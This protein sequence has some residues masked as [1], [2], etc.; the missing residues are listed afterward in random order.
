M[1][2]SGREPLETIFMKRTLRNVF[3]VLTVF[4]ISRACVVIGIF[5][6]RKFL[7]FPADLSNKVLEKTWWESLARW[8]AGYYIDIVLNGYHYLPDGKTHNIAFFPLY[9]LLIRIVDD[10]TKLSPLM[11][12]IIISNACF[13]VALLLLHRY[14]EKYHPDSNPDLTAMLMAFFPFG[15]FFSSV[16]TE[17]LFLC[18]C[19]FSFFMFREGKTMLSAIGL[20]LMTAT[21]LAG[22]FVVPALGLSYLFT[23]VIPFPKKKS[24]LKGRELLNLVVWG[25]VAISGFVCFAAY[26]QISFGHWDAFIR[27]QIAWKDRVG[28]FSSL[29]SEMHPDLYNVMNIVPAGILLGASILFLF[30]KNYRIYSV[31]G[32]LAVL[33]PLSTGTF[34]SMGRYSMVF[35]PLAIYGGCLLKKTAILRDIALMTSSSLLVVLSTLFAKYYFIG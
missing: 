23:R 29:L 24:P 17:S 30:L 13:L 18:L 10:I 9:P 5:L 7:S 19:L 22:L 4:V 6:G 14:T 27:V 35:F 16:Y 11:S 33:I 25:L 2:V 28:N 26:Q 21:R 8:D 15:V 12:G 20:F 31:W 3:F 32:L 1:Q 34:M